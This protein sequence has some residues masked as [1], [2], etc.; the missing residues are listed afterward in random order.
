MAATVIPNLAATLPVG[1]ACSAVSE[2]ALM[3][4]TSEDPD[5][6]MPPGSGPFSKRA[7]GDPVREF[8]HLL[9]AWLADGRPEGVFYP[10]G[11]T[12]G[13]TATYTFNGTGIDWV[14]SIANN[15]GKAEVYIDGTLDA[16][17]DN[18][19]VNYLQ[20]QVKY[21]KSGLTSG[22]HTIKIKVLHSKNA[23]STGYKQNVDGFYVH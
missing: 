4:V 11:S 8:A 5:Y 19:S 22:T 17:V 7:E 14:G 6:V 15:H 2:E 12:S 9:E 18:Y 16:T 21:S 20:Q 23:S 13:D 1:D 10:E 3:R